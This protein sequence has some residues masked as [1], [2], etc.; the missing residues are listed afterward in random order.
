MHRQCTA[1]RQELLSPAVL[2]SLFHLAL[3]AL[4]FLQATRQSVPEQKHVRQRD[5]GQRLIAALPDQ[6]CLLPPY[7]WSAAPFMARL[8][9]G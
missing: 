8:R 4:N 2:W 1:S 5:R 7:A 9:A 3:L 6:R